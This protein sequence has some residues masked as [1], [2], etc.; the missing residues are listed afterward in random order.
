MC[1]LFLR[2]LEFMTL[3]EATITAP[4]VCF[5]LVSSVNCFLTVMFEVRF[6]VTC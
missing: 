6:F 4:G 2:L 5:F 1:V 3:P